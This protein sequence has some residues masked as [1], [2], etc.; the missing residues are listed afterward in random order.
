MKLDHLKP[1]YLVPETGDYLVRRDDTVS[2]LRMLAEELPMEVPTC[3]DI[4][5]AHEVWL[6]L[7]RKNGEIFCPSAYALSRLPYEGY[8]PILIRP[9]AKESVGT[10]PTDIEIS[11]AIH[12]GVP[13]EKMTFETLM[14]W[15]DKRRLEGGIGGSPRTGG[16]V[17]QYRANGSLVT[18]SVDFWKG[19]SLHPE[20]VRGS[21]YDYEEELGV[22]TPKER[23]LRDL[24]GI[25]RD[26]IEDYLRARDEVQERALS[27]MRK[28]RKEGI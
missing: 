11:L 1:Q 4:R 20:A 15:I 16:I 3:E 14:G 27:R 9:G 2:R 22:P 18:A 13:L 6:E 21:D 25:P 10:P 7:R 5:N 12:R 8:A 19:I 26:V 23:Y 24:R 28:K 17:V